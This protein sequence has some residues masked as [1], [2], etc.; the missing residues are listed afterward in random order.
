M[1]GEFNFASDP[2]AAYIV[3]N[4]YQCET[5]LACWEFTCYSQLPWVRLVITPK[6]NLLLDELKHPAQL[7][8]LEYCVIV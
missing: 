5:Y 1:C 3:L 6:S 2:E 8:Y 7:N 4:D